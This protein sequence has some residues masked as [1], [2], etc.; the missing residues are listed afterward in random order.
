MI[1]VEKRVCQAMTSDYKEGGYTVVMYFSGN[2]A[3]LGISGDGWAAVCERSNVP[4]K[5]LALIVEHAGDLPAAGQA[6]TL[7]KDCEPQNT[8]FNVAVEEFE[9]MMAWLDDTEP[10]RM[11]RTPLHLRA[12]RLWQNEKSGAIW[13]IS[14]RLSAMADTAPEYTTAAGNRMCL[15]GSVSAVFVDREAV[16]R[17]GEGELI[18]HLE[19]MRWA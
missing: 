4:R 15:R 19:K 6:W 5:V 12:F 7:E 1:L 14:P 13:K 9:R 2:D 11:N 18:A 16:S 17:K 8:E 3:W 10:E